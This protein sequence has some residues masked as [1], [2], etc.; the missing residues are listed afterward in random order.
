MTPRKHKEKEIMTFSSWPSWDDLCKTGL[1]DYEEFFTNK[2]YFKGKMLILGSE[3]AILLKRKLRPLKSNFRS[4][5]MSGLNIVHV[6]R[7]KYYFYGEEIE[8]Q[9]ILK[10]MRLEDQ[11]PD[12]ITCR[13]VFL[14]STMSPNNNMS[15]E[16]PSP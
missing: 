16:N 10:R 5:K 8:G 13:C 2:D 1:P 11:A 14:D 12:G 4:L 6:L 3:S 9:K 7:L 15:K